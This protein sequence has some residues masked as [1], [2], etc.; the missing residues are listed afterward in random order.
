MTEFQASMFETFSSEIV[1]V[2]STHKTNQY[3]FKLITVVVSDEY[4]NGIIMLNGRVEDF[5]ASCQTGQPVAWA[6]SD[7]EDASTLEAVWNM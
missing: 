2:D 7:K 4:H 3:Q 1:C 5:I 6:I